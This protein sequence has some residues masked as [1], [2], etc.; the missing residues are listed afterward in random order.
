MTT[1]G[2]S[3]SQAWKTWATL[4]SF[5]DPEEANALC[6]FLRQEGINTQVQD[7]RRLQRWWFL[8]QPLAGIHVRVPGASFEDAQSI[9]QGNPASVRFLRRAIRCPS[10]NSVRVQYPQM[11]RKN[12]LPTLVAQGLVFMRVMKRECYCETCHYTWVPGQ[13]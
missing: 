8:A 9:L 5:N 13:K 3:R 10:C 7:E 1:L 4:A 12:I 11:T 6:E 2:S